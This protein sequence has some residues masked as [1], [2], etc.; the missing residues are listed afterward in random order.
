M[1]HCVDEIAVLI[2]NEIYSSL[3]LRTRA[4]EERN[5]EAYQAPSRYDTRRTIYDVL[6]KHMEVLGQSRTEEN[7]KQIFPNGQ[8][9][10]YKTYQLEKMG[11]EIG[12]SLIERKSDVA[13][14]DTYEDDYIY[15]ESIRIMILKPARIR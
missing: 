15:K 9:D 13:I 1:E 12:K 10:D 7:I 3:D 4:L 11:H 6:M 14:I 2:T 5:N 8:P